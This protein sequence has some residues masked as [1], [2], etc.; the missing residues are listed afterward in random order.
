MS[1]GQTQITVIAE[2]LR[3]YRNARGIS[4]EV[5]ADEIGIDR[6]YLSD[7][8]NAK[9]NPSLNVLTSI[10][11]YFGISL[12]LFFQLI[13]NRISFGNDLDNVKAMLRDLDFEDSIVFENPAYI[14]AICGINEKGQLCY[15]YPLMILALM[16]NDELT[17]EDAAEFID[18]NT[19]RALPYM[20]EYAP[21]IIYHIS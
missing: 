3:N 1:N 15:A 12:A 20:G 13:D 9:R 8:E 18:Y 21:V 2:L 19:V 5:C 10:A 16:L 4:Q 6:R 7:L 14:E 17:Y 11:S